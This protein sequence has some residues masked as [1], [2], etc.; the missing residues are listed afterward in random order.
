MSLNL[1]APDGGIQPLLSL[2]ASGDVTWLGSPKPL[3]RLDA[4]GCLFGDDGVWMEVLPD[5]SLWTLREVYQSRGNRWS[6]GPGR[7]FQIESD[8]TVVSLRDDQVQPSTE[9]TLRF[10]GFSEPG[11]CAASTL[12]VVFLGM[13]PSMAVSD[14]HPV[15]LPP[16]KNSLCPRH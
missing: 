1:S 9:G 12:L 2:S 10:S 5:A 3:A 11:R 15:V 13:A 16:P 6:S 8:G 4:N 14:G 7:A